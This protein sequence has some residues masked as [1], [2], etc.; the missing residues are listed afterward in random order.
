MLVLLVMSASPASA[1][2]AEPDAAATMRWGPLSLQSTLALSNLGGDTNV[3]NR[4]AETQLPGDFTLT[5]T[6]T[7]N[8][9]LR[10]GR[11][12]I[13]GTIQ[14]DW[15][16]FNRYPSERGAN[17]RYRI[18]VTRTFN[19]LRFNAGATRTST[20]DR[21]NFEIDARSQ[22]FVKLFTGEAEYRVLGKTSF[23]VKG[24][25]RTISF[26]KDA[27]FLGTSL[28]I[29]LN[30]E[31]ASKSVFMRHVLTP[32]TSVGLEMGRENHRFFLPLR[33]ADSNRVIGN[34]ALQPSALISGNAQFGYRH[35]RPWNRGIPAYRGPTFIANLTYAMRGTTRL[36]VDA[37]RDLQQ[38][39]N[40]AQPY[41]LETGAV[42]SV[43]Q[44][45]RGPF[46]VMGR[47]GRFRMAYRDLIGATVDISKRVDR[48]NSVGAGAGYRLGD[49]K[50]VGFTVDRVRRISGIEQRRYNAVRYG[51]SVTYER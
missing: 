33:N 19:R 11:T 49:D 12:W 32:L 31:T 3:F 15:V 50:R 44:Q 43:Q 22:R 2:T 41:F 40:A 14:V 48:V 18:G 39:F 42:W 17:S 1:Q 20:R 5:F 51:F 28:A 10:M 26:D 7:N 34:I 24:Q 4:P 8:L 30:E 35:Y 37:V 16:Y 47:T 27:V 9:W 6:P 45:V 21:P 46:D 29:A 38:S 25:H 13:D 36:R 23:G